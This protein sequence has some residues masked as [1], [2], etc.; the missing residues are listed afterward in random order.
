MSFC[1][2]GVTPLGC[3]ERFKPA[4]R[5]L[6]IWN[7]LLVVS[8]ER[9][10]LSRSE[11]WKMIKRAGLNTSGSLALNMLRSRLLLFFFFFLECFAMNVPPFNSCAFMDSLFLIVLEKGSEV[12]SH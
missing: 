7:K 2:I 4:V 9:S 6:M 5:D 3:T 11:L 10:R 8:L 12:K 1:A